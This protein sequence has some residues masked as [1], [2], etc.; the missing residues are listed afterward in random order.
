MSQ[1]VTRE[2]FG[3]MNY[4][5]NM[6]FSGGKVK[7]RKD[8]P[9]ASAWMDK[10][11]NVDGYIYPPEM[12]TVQGDLS[13]SA[14]PTVVP[15]TMRPARVFSLPLSHRLVLD[16]PIEPTDLRHGDAGLII[17]LLAF[18]FGTR[19]QFKG[20]RFDGRVPTKSHNSFTY[21]PD[22]PCHFVS[23]VYDKWRNWPTGARRR[24]VNIL[25]MFSR[26]FSYEWEWDRFA[27]QY[28]VL[29]AIYKLH[30][31]LG[32]KSAKGHRHR[33]EL[34]CAEYGVAHDAG[35]AAQI[36]DL[37]NDLF[38]EAIW[39]SQT[40]GSGQ[41]QKYLYPKWL[42]RLNT[43]LIVAITGYRNSL[44]TQGWWFFGWQPF[45]KSK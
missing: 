45:D 27:N 34:L 32:G 37:R 40:P 19:L 23:H 39:D 43:R 41:S 20:W 8:F 18:F 22:V 11:K 44:L 29:D 15:N 13:D 28:M 42:A 21:R 9:S 16:S 33:L 30:Q 35:M 26:C 38:H 3:F 17:H 25:Y 6:A 7:V 24:F 2:S 14:V 12:Q 5:N 4:P 10:Y 31:E 36:C 1:N